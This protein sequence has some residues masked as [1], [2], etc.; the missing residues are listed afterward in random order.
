MP[1]NEVA[2]LVDAQRQLRE[3]FMTAP[4]PDASRVVSREHFVAQSAGPADDVEIEP[5][6]VGVPAEWVR[7]PVADRT[8]LYLHGGGYV[9]GDMVERRE[10]IARVARPGR[11]QALSVNY[12]L[13]PA[14][15]YPAALD[16]A[17]TAD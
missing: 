11:G 3:S 6:P 17:L 15:P 12:R 2:A 5:A 1:S 9:S 10:T 8:V 7:P 14:H 4:D 13:A 16:D